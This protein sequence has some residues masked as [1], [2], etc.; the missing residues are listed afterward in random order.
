MSEP[1]F[2]LLEA[3]WIPARRSDGT[4][5]TLGLLSVFREAGQL[6]GLADEGP[7]RQV[8][9]Y[10]LLL[11]ILARA[12]ARAGI[13]VDE[14]LEAGF[15]AQ[16]VEDYLEHW[17]EAFWLIHPDRPFLQ[18]PFLADD[19]VGKRL[20]SWTNLAPERATGNNATLFDHSVDAAPEPI[21]LPLAARTLIGFLQFAP[22]GT[23]KAFRTS[24]NA[25]PLA[26]TAAVLPLGRNLAETFLLAV[27]EPDPRDAPSWEHP[28]P[29][30]AALKRGD[31]R[32]PEGEC[33]RYTWRSRSVLL[34]PETDPDGEEWVRWIHFTEGQPMAADPQS[35]DPMAA[36]RIRNGQPRR[37]S[38]E[39]GR[40]IWRD[41]PALLPDPD[42]GSA[43]PPAVMDWAADR[44]LRSGQAD[45]EGVH[46]PV[47]VGGLA[48]NQSKPLRWRAESVTL[49][50]KV[51][52]VPG[53][54][55]SLRS[56]VEQAETTGRRLSSIA[57]HSAFM[58]LPETPYRKQKA[59]N[60][61]QGLGVESAY[62]AG[63]EQALPRVL[64]HYAAGDL[65]QAEVTWADAQCKA[66]DRAWQQ[67]AASLG[68][69]VAAIRA[70]A[71][72]EG[73]LR[74]LIRELRAPLSDQSAR[75]EEASP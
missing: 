33:E 1:R 40:A 58:M 36:H 61:L 30:R 17:R 2:Q 37:V 55:Q 20:K 69:S 14:A 24:D 49:P 74:A 7:T 11:A 43:Q 19:P 9:L 8:A 51:L 67:L 54:T 4:T 27:H 12:M 29:E 50:T 42:R 32:T 26:N 73:W 62:Y 34:A 72:N 38:F 65:E 23:V 18:T 10:R 57:W 31:E 70:V 64:E 39:S 28:L 13:S 63:L 56:Q 15:P 25:A 5:T 52:S 3:P 16:A 66:L 59:K 45:L 21:S 6:Q 53:A 41:L 75:P 35:P 71:R 22:G 44:L 47:F 68:P 60:L 46:I 48:S